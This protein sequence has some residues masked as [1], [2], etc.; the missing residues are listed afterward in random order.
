MLA[1]DRH[2]PQARANASACCTGTPSPISDW[3]SSAFDVLWSWR[4]P[5]ATDHFFAISLAPPCEA[6]P[7][8]PH[9]VQNPDSMQGML[10]C[11]NVT[12]GTTDVR[13]HCVDTDVAARVLAGLDCDMWRGHR[14]P[15]TGFNAALSASRGNAGH[16]VARR[17]RSP[18]VPLMQGDADMDSAEWLA[19][20]ASVRVAQEVTR[21]WFPPSRSRT[22]VTVPGLGRQVRISRRSRDVGSPDG[23][24]TASGAC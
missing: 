4:P 12:G 2:R 6:P 22:L 23:S 21:S 15:R 10:L 9:T 19:R 24:K 17:D 18:A 1:L 3:R 7:Q 5:G 11:R 13:R 16:A 8:R 20:E 14:G